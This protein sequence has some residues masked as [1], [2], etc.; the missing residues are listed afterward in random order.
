M[1]LQ[2]LRL[3]EWAVHRWQYYVTNWDNMVWAT[4]ALLAGPP[5]RHAPSAAAMDEYLVKWRQG[6]VVRFL[7]LHEHDRMA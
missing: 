5:A 4:Q 2:T 1:I 6:Q 7:C 3:S